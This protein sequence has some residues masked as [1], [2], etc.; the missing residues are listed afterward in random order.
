MPAEPEAGTRHDPLRARGTLTVR[1][2]SSG[3]ADALEAALA[4]GAGEDVP[5]SHAEVARRGLELSIVLAAEDA[6]ALRAAVNAYLRWVQ[7]T[8]DVHAVARE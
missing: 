8:A 4:G 5:G 7:L 3:Q 2:D 1:A 6:G